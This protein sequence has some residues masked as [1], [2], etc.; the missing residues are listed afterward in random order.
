M[1][2]VLIIGM[3]FFFFMMFHMFYIDKIHKTVYKIVSSFNTKLFCIGFDH[4]H[5]VNSIFS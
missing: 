1:K 3:R 5:L 4:R 2:L